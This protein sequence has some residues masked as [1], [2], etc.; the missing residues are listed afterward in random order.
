MPPNRNKTFRL[1]LITLLLF[2]I[3]V[4]EAAETSLI[5]LSAITA[6]K[7]I[8]WI[9]PLVGLQ[10]L[11]ATFQSSFSD[12]YSRRTSL[13]ISV[14]VTIISLC[15]FKISHV[16]GFSFLV[17]A[18]I[19]KG[20]AGNTIPI[21]R[22]GLADITLGHNFRF[23]LAMSICA[24][25]LGSWGPMFLISY[26]GGAKL[27]FLVMVLAAAAL[28]LLLIQEIGDKEH[29][30]SKMQSEDPFYEL[31]KGF[32]GF[33]RLFKR[34]CYV[35]FNDFLKRPPFS[36]AMLAY[37]FAE[38]SFYQILFRLEVLR[39]YF[40][41]FNVPI[42]LGIG[43]Y[44]GTAILKFSRMK[45]K[46]NIIL[47]A[48]VSFLCILT[49]FLMSYFKFENKIITGSLFGVYSLGFALFI[50]CLFSAISRRRTPYDQGKI[51]GL[52]DSTDTCAAILAFGLVLG[53]RSISCTTV[54]FISTILFILSAV[55]FYGLFRINRVSYED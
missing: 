4:D 6:A 14:V 17:A 22:A 23:A 7:Q 29:P 39:N 19:L 32:K 33:I 27:Y 21:A 49:V 5:K 16:Y 30:P 35:I 24:I 1:Y 42:E 55:T 44:V 15:F 47:G 13:I 52:V 51:Y 41:F 3:F 34:D 18:L 28:L 37:F 10:V 54:L 40:C 50:P 36:V 31:F 26:I 25:A 45:N 11:F 8:G 48:W 53:L 46:S 20:I 43:Y 2:F 12:Y 9:F 38:A